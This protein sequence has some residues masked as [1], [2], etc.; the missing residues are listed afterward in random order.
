VDFWKILALYST[1]TGY[2]RVS[3]LG[4]LVARVS[5]QLDGQTQRSASSLD[6]GTSNR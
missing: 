3:L 4:I 2:A 1:T 5:G 6:T